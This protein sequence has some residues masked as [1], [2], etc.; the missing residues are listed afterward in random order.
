[1]TY[2]TQCWTV[3]TAEGKVPLTFVTKKSAL[4]WIA[5]QTDPSLYTI[6]KHSMR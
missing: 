2:Y 1:M 4:L 6:T 5:E 3:N